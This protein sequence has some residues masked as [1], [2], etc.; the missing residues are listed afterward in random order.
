MFVMQLSKM[1]VSENAQQA[2]AGDWIKD[3]IY[4]SQFVN[5]LKRRSSGLEVVCVPYFRLQKI[6]SSEKH[7]NRT[8][9]IDFVL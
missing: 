4:V 1:F 6:K 8:F 7:S 9:I 5:L 3:H 2:D